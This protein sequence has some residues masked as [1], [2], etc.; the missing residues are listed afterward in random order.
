[1]FP[2]ELQEAKSRVS[3]L[4]SAQKEMKLLRQQ[5]EGTELANKQ[6]RVCMALVCVRVCVCACV[7]VCVCMCV[8]VH[9]CVCVCVCACMCVC[10]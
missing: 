8:C 4:E 10:V 2:Q 3:R 1:M 9:V 7:C 5:S 6:I